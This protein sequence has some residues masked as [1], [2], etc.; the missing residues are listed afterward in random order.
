MTVG[1]RIKIRRK[2]LG[3]SADELAIKIGKDRSTVFRYERGDIEN[4]PLDV[5]QPIANALLI[6]PQALM[7]WEETDTTTENSSSISEAKRELLDLVESCS[8]EEVSRLLQM[9]ELFL[10]RK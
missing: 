1:K 2:E 10:G 8:D 9:M 4:L 3:M 7:G 5:L 6:T